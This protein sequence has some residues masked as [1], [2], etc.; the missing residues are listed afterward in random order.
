M[1]GF[2]AFCRQSLDQIRAQGRYREFTP[3]QKQAAAFPYDRRPDGAEVLVWSSNDYLA[4]GG[5]DVAIAAACAA[6]QEMGAGAGGT[7]NISGTSPAHDALEVELAAMHGKDAALLFTS[8]FVSNEAALSTLLNSRPEGPE[9]SW[10]V[11]SDAKTSFKAWRW[12][13]RVR[14]GLCHLF[15]AVFRPAPS[16]LPAARSRPSP[17]FSDRPKS[18]AFLKPGRSLLFQTIRSALSRAEFCC[19]IAAVEQQQSEMTGFCL[20]LGPAHAFGLDGV[21]G[22]AQ[23]RR[24]GDMDG[25]AAQ[26]QPHARS[27]PGWCRGSRKQWRCRA[28]PRH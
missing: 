20:G 8:G 19:G 14:A 16:M 10:Q 15:P 28:G 9:V 1:V 5:H 17:L 26:I 18:V 27:R 2:R 6:A 4:M 3:L 23:A 13:G 25:I 21:S 24:V 11:F 12:R 22:V 7:R